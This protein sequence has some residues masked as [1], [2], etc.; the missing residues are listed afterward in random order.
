MRITVVLLFVLLFQARGEVTYSQSTRISLDLKNAT[1][2]EVLNAIEESSEFYFL[3]NNKLINADRRVDVKA[4]NKPVT[5]ILD[6]VFDATDVQYQVD[7]R[8]IILSKK[9]LMQ[10]A[11]PQQGRKITGT[12]K[13]DRGE[14]VIGASVVL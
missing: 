9:S 8:Q 7:D 2:E 10:A 4:K 12:V 1:V 11:V 14:P 3:Y 6:Q 5:T 13:D